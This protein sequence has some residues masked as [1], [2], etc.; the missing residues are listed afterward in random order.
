MSLST[1]SNR[2]QSDIEYQSNEQYVK[3]NILGK[4]YHVKQSLITNLDDLKQF[5]DRNRHEY[6]LDIS[7]LIFDHIIEY[8]STKKLNLP[9]NISMNYYK[10]TL[11]KLRIDTSSLNIRQY[12]ERIVPR[13]TNRQILH[14][15]FEYPDCRLISFFIYIFSPMI[16][17]CRLARVLHYMCSMIALLSCLIVSLSLTYRD[18]TKDL[19]HWNLTEH[20]RPMNS[21]MFIAHFQNSLSKFFIIDC[22]C[23]CWI[24]IETCVRLFSAVSLYDYLSNLGLFDIIGK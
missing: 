24:I 3:F 23:L 1:S 20:D 15:L 14:V 16:L 19:F 2:L 6:I 7:P 9:T 4:I 12:H 8:Y 22:I 5:F 10:D 18:S 17:A 13:G 11:D 21:K